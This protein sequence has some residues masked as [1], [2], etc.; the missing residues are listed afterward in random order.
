[1]TNF[2][3]LTNEQLNKMTKA[4]LIEL[5]HE[6][7]EQLNKR[8]VQKSN[9]KYDVL[10]ILQEQSPISI[11]DISNI[12]E[13]STKNVSSLLTYLRKDGHKIHTDCEGRK[14]LVTEEQ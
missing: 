2:N 6:A 5:I 10:K 3:E 1:M 12:M 11:L 8:R 7:T 14:Y 9:K 4:Q 13:I